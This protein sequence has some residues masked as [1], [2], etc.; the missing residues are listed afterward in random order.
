MPIATAMKQIYPITVLVMLA[1][2]FCLAVAGR[3]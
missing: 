3:F 2:T 1:I